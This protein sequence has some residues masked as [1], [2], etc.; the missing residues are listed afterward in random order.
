MHYF[1]VL[2]HLSGLLNYCV[3]GWGGVGVLPVVCPCNLTARPTEVILERLDALAIQ[4]FML[5]LSESFM[6]VLML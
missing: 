4:E 3:L 1:Q 6:C 5:S 2:C